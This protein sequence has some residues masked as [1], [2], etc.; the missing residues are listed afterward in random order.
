MLDIILAFVHAADDPAKRLSIFGSRIDPEIIELLF[1]QLFQRRRGGRI[2]LRRQF[3]HAVKICHRVN[4][5]TFLLRESKKPFN[6]FDHALQNDAIELVIG[7]YQ[8][9]AELR[10]DGRSNWLIFVGLNCLVMV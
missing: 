4:R 3:F 6:R 2:S 10:E 5:H 9:R 7:Y 8:G 1:Y